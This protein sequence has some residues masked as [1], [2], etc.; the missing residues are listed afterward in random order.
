MEVL[1]SSVKRRLNLCR[2]EVEAD[3]VQLL[4]QT[5]RPH[6]RCIGEHQD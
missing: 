6:G 2:D 3:T 4:R 5:F 1:A